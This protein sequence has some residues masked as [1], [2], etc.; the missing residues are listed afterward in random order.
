MG[1]RQTL[2][3]KQLA[4]NYK[5]SCREPSQAFTLIELL[6]VISIIALLLAILLPSL[7]QARMQ[8]YNVVCLANLRTLWIAWVA[9]TDDNNNDLVPGHTGRDQWINNPVPEINDTIE[10]EKAGIRKGL[11]F[12]YV[13]DVDAYRCP[14]DKRPKRDGNGFR[15]YSITGA[16]NGEGG[17]YVFGKLT[18]IKPLNKYFVF[19]EEPDPRGYNMGSWLINPYSSDRWI[20]PLSIWHQE[21]GSLCFADGH[22]EVHKWVDRSTIDMSRAQV[23]YYWLYS[24]DSGD[25]LRYMQEHYC[26]REK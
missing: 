14:L 18:E 20:D 1:L 19:V 12:S 16:M 10:A 17:D 21:S 13:Q 23:F 3:P 24:D 7:R 6:V 9:Y 15:S 26:Y 2:I 25:D 11:L 8:A 5:Y 4:A 22:S